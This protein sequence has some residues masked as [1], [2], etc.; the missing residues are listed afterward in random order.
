M[1]IAPAAEKR[2]RLFECTTKPQIDARLDFAGP[3]PWPS[4]LCLN[5]SEIHSSGFPR[6]SASSI[7]SSRVH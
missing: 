4:L 1:V 2:H 3:P 5:P 7:S 6:D